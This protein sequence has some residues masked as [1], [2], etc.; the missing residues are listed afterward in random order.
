MTISEVLT[1]AF[2]IIIGIG[3]G[4]REFAVFIASHRRR[5]RGGDRLIMIYMPAQLI[6]RLFIS[7]L[8]VLVALFIA[9]SILAARSWQLPVLSSV[10]LLLTLAGVLALF[11]LI[12][13]DLRGT[14][15]QYHDARHDVIN[16]LKN[17]HAAP[18]RDGEQ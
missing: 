8:V 12:I 13:K 17:D 3:Y 6:R 7:G 11:I 15:R 2:F 18:P 4:V 10:M 1:L 9:F 5:D 16:L 14:F